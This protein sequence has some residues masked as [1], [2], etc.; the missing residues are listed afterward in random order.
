[1]NRDDVRRKLIE[2]AERGDST[3]GDFRR[4][5]LREMYDLGCLTHDEYILM[6]TWIEV[7]EAVE[8][9]DRQILEYHESISPE[10]GIDSQ[11][12]NDNRSRI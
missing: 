12:A 3:V 2:F 11:N 1:M 5:W 10:K 8:G 9:L 6:I 7:E 4:Q